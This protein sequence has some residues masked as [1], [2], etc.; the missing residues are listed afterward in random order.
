V[1]VSAVSLPAST[2]LSP[3]RLGTQNDH[4][5][6]GYQK[7]ETYIL[8]KSKDVYLH[9]T[10]GHAER[11]SKVALICISDIKKNRVTT[12]RPDNFIPVERPLPTEQEARCD[13]Q[14]VGAIWSR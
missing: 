2:E 10:K 11:G 3:L 12:S 8:H 1:C 14:P 7:L 9:A 4:L 5:T 13:P 6:H